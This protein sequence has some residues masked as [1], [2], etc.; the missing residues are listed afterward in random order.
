MRL[1]APTEPEATHDSPGFIEVGGSTE[2]QGT[3]YFGWTKETWFNDRFQIG[4]KKRMC[5][6]SAHSG[7]DA[8]LQLREPLGAERPEH[9]EASVSGVTMEHAGWPCDPTEGPG[10]ARLN[11]P[12]CVAAALVCGQVT[13]DEFTSDA[14]ADPEL[15]D[16]AG[17]VT[18][19]HDPGI[20]RLGRAH[21]H[22]TRVRSQCGSGRVLEAEVVT[23]LGSQG[24]PLSRRD[25]LEKVRFL[26]DQ[27]VGRDRGHRI[28]S[29]VDSINDLTDLGSVVR[30]LQG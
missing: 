24:R 1:S 27:S 18:T 28:A 26:A 4:Y 20:D 30:E 15:V 8:A 19:L 21:R 3:G 10:S 9:V 16:M 2:A 29:M 23:G 6:A 12:W 25:L 22:Q 5:D 11:V 13:V 7:I 14:L 17:R